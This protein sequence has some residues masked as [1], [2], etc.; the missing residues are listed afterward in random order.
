MEKFITITDTTTG[1]KHLMSLNG[2]AGISSTTTAMTLEYTT[3]VADGLASYVITH[4]TAPSATSFRIWFVEQMEA[5]LATDSRR[6][7]AEPTPPY[8]V[9]GIA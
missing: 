7:T 4:D 8:T 5:I 9:T 6:V 2:I 3:P 1:Q